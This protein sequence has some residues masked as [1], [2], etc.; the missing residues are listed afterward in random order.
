[1][2]FEALLQYLTGS[3]GAGAAKAKA[4]KLE[5]YDMK[6][7]Q[8]ATRVHHQ[9]EKKTKRAVKAAAAADCSSSSPSV[10]SSPSPSLSPSLSMAASSM[11]AGDR[12][13]LEIRQ[14]M[15][16]AQLH[17]PTRYRRTIL[18]RQVDA[19]KRFLA[20]VFASS[21]LG[22]L[23]RTYFH[24]LLNK[25][26]RFP[27]FMSDEL[28]GDVIALGREM[29]AVREVAPECAS[30]RHSK[31]PLV[32]E[33]PFMAWWA[34][35][36]EQY[37]EELRFFNALK[38]DP[39]R[40]FLTASDF[41]PFLARMVHETCPSLD[42]LRDTP[43]FQE[44]YLDT[45]IALVLYYNDRR[46]DGRISFE[47]FRRSGLVDIFKR[48]EAEP[49][50]NHFERYFSYK[51]FYVI[52]RKFW[53]L[54]TDHDM[55]LSIG[56]LAHYNQKSLSTRVLKQ[57][58]HLLPHLGPTI[59]TPQDLERDRAVVA[60]AAAS[61]AA[62]DGFTSSPSPL[63]P[64]PSVSP[65]R[66]ATPRGSPD[67]PRRLRLSLSPIVSPP[68]AAAGSTTADPLNFSL[69]RSAAPIGVDVMERRRLAR[70]RPVQEKRMNFMQFVWFIVSEEDKTS[71]HSWRYWFS[72]ADRDSDGVISA[73]DIEYFYE[74][75]MQ[76]QRNTT[77]DLDIVPFGDV[78][79]QSTDMHGGKIAI[80]Y[81]DVKA[82]GQAP[83]FFNMLF[84]LHKFLADE[85]SN[86]FDSSAYRVSPD[87]PSQW[88]QFA[89]REYKIAAL[90][91]AL[92][93]SSN[94]EELS[95]SSSPCESPV[96]DFSDDED[97]E[98]EAEDDERAY[99][100]DDQQRYSGSTSSYEDDESTCSS[101]DD[102]GDEGDYSYGS[103]S[104]P[105]SGSDDIDSDGS[106]SSTLSGSPRSDHF[107]ADRNDDE[108]QYLDENE[109][110][111]S[112]SALS[113]SISAHHLV[114]SAASSSSSSSL[115]SSSSSRR[116]LT[117]ASPSSLSLPSS[118]SSSMYAKF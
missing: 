21:S 10:H 17:F 49:D 99:D 5:K 76:R 86:P 100:D 9:Q 97:E 92:N 14:T 11:S 30:T 48:I 67:A 18:R 37:S 29:G 42:F 106:Y 60:A 109:L 23:T 110:I 65:R 34:H 69:Q 54:D 104:T 107:D 81:L 70:N 117:A 72:V 35:H 91:E 113:T 89:L 83:L 52:Y 116:K 32:L 25:L 41:R 111:S 39:S 8:L 51:H 94:E 68:R 57:I 43:V 28:F 36:L 13:S 118:P 101:T 80:T 98:A 115:S 79:Q 85:H 45:V 55:I 53:E 93:Q 7:S 102:D 88:Q 62:C 114:N 40:E 3:T 31:K 19:E 82:S 4:A 1:M 61:L 38:R 2:V 96:F 47:Q 78:M 16:S 87:G 75:Q 22:G 74:E 90:E 103:S 58:F 66:P 77:A 112:S 95:T 27:R 56:D 26:C 63:S 20:S 15:A 50:I 12:T 6:K 71:E 24:K 73:Y 44:R 33:R 108:R 64:S 46:R 105:S 84:N 59:V